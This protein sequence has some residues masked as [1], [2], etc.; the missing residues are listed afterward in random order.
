MPDETPDGLPG[1][2]AHGI[3]G[4]PELVELA[5]VLTATVARVAEQHELTP[6]QGRLLCGLGDQPQ[7]MVDLAQLLGIEKAALTGL[8][9]RAERRG[10]LERGPVPGDRR[11]VQVSLTDAGTQAVAAFE[12]GV[13]SALDG[14]L[15]TLPAGDRPEFRR[16]ASAVVLAARGARAA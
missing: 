2:A 7:R 1:C 15:A 3:G 4:M 13:T 8:V 14:L 16:L 9:D 12:A 10:L 6:M 11:A 5:V